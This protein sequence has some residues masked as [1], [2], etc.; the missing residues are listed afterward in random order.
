[1]KKIVLAAILTLVATSAFAGIAGS[2]HD[3]SSIG[4]QTIRGAG[5]AGEGSDQ[6]CIYCHVPHNAKASLPL[7]N[8]EATAYTGANNTLYTTSSTLSPAAAASYLNAT[9]ISMTCLSCHDGALGATG[10]STVGDRVTRN[11]SGAAKITMNAG[12]WTVGGLFDGANS[13]TNDHPVGF[14]YVQSATTKGVTSIVPA[15]SS[16][17]VASLP[18][19]TNAAKNVTTAGTGD[20]NVECATCHLVHDN[21][22]GKFLRVANTGSALCLKCHVK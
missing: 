1:M 11:S 8:R 6:L 2:K 7:W 14:N 5:T 10:Q 20:S 4:T 16:V 22:N 21:T 18:L 9:S 3:L 17:L 15:T 13:L 12:V 19:Y